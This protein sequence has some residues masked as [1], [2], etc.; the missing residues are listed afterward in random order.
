MSAK[1]C[2]KGHRY[3]K[4]SDCPVCPI[5][6]KEKVP[7]AAFHAL[8]SGPARRALEHAGVMSLKVLSGWTEKEV[9]ALHGMGPASLPILREALQ[10]EGLVFKV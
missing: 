10:S 6:E 5:C 2:P 1:T 9:L 4:S 8:L 7:A 3:Q